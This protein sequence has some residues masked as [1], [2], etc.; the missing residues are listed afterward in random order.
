MHSNLSLVIKLTAQLPLV[1]FN[2]IIVATYFPSRMSYN[3]IQSSS[4]LDI[5][6][7]PLGLKSTQL[8]FW[9]FSRYVLATLKLRITPSVIFMS[10]AESFFFSCKNILHIKTK[11]LPSTSAPSVASGLMRPASHFCCLWS[12]RATHEQH[13]SRPFTRSSHFLQNNNEI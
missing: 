10:A 8:I 11:R 5:A 7:S 1:F 3:T 2:V 4:L 9:E 13:H 12:G 6:F